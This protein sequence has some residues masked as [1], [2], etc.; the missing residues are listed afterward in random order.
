ML[1]EEVR[2]RFIVTVY[3]WGLKSRKI[4]SVGTRMPWQALRYIWWR[5]SWLVALMTPDEKELEQLWSSE[6]NHCETN[7]SHSLSFSQVAATLIAIVASANA[8]SVNPTFSRTST[9][10][11][12]GPTIG[13]GG[14]ADTRDPDAF[15][16]EDPRKSISA[17]P[18]FEEYLKN[19]DGGGG[20]AAPAAAA[21][22]APAAA[23]GGDSKYGKYDDQM[24]D[25][26][27]KKEIYAAWDPNS[28]RSPMNFN[29]FETFEGNTPDAS[30][31]YPGEGWYKDPSRGDVNFQTMMVE[32]E[33]ADERA[34][35]PK[36]GD[37]P[38]CPG[39]RN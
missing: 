12:G 20:D 29:P 37:K 18:S 19:R 21:D 10:V 17:A 36:A 8:F 5:S 39:C 28:P 14:M 1:I 6:C 7:Y 15:E 24:W 26:E 23:A 25:N 9:A 13:A 27:A 11:F 31:F 4:K 32:R 2:G 35:N 3:D 34:A 22:A 16:D 38:G 33:E 30:G